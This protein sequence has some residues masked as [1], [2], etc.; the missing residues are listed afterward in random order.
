MVYFKVLSWRVPTGIVNEAIK[1]QGTWPL[2]ENRPFQDINPYTTAPVRR[3]CIRVN[4]CLIHVLQRNG[5]TSR[6]KT[7]TDK[8][9][10]DDKTTTA[11]LSLHRTNVHTNN[12]IQTRRPVQDSTSHEKTTQRVS[13]LWMRHTASALQ[14]TAHPRHVKSIKLSGLHYRLALFIPMEWVLGQVSGVKP[15]PSL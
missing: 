13:V 15:W 9:S 3:A 10:D 7:K 14:H 11:L 5:G 4:Q 12:K 2:H 1:R 8:A 6:T